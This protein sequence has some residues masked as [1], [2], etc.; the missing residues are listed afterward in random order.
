MQTLPEKQKS[1][2]IFRFHGI[3]WCTSRTHIRT[4]LRFH[5]FPES[6]RF[7]TFLIVKGNKY[8]II[9]EIDGI[10]EGIHQC[11]PLLRLGHVQLAEAKQPKP[12]EL[13]FHL[14]LSQPFLCN[15]GLQ[16]LPLLFQRFQPLLCG[17]GQDA[18]LDGVQHIG[19]ANFRFFQLLFIDGQIRAFLILQFH[20]FGNDGI[21]GSVIFHQLH[22]LVDHQ[23]F[24]PL[25]P[26]G[27]FIAGLFLLGSSTLVVGIHFPG[28]ADTAF[29]E[30][31]RPTVAAEQ[32]GGEQIIVL[33]LSTGRSFLVFCDFLLHILKQFQ[34]NDGRD[35]IRYDHIPEFQFSDV[36]PVLEHM[37]NAVIS[38][39]TAH[40]VLDAVFVQPVPNLL[41]SGAFIVLL[42]RFKHKRRG[43]RVN[44]ELPLRIQRVTK[45]STTTVAAAFQDVLGLS[46]H[47][48][49][50][51]VS[52]VVFRIAFQ[53]RFQ[54]NALRPLGDDLGG[55]HELDAVLLQLGLIP[56]TVVAVPGKTVQLPDQHN[57]KQLLVAVLN[58]LLELRAVVRLGGDSTVNIVL[59]DG[60]AVFLGISRAFPDLAFDGFFALVVRGIASIDHGG[61][62]GHLHFIRH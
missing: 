31:Q 42:E 34:W 54:N 30:H 51:K 52:G 44:V 60:D 33:C 23:I 22:G 3:F 19:D 36:P 12:D 27:L 32:L 28:V 9:V 14:W 45:G 50:G 53:H 37:F 26:H 43:E 6:D 10:D 2:E 56:G 46:T 40:R 39:C 21:H 47:D 1:H 16:F 8:L 29:S 7:C 18:H 20:D 4:F 5:S 49:L 48:L 17:A 61:H 13:L 25:F 11:L 58:H 41:H 35:S 59:D 57:V 15:A 55:R 24:Q 38:K 62:G